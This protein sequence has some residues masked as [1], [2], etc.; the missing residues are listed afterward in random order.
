MSEQSTTTVERYR[1]TDD[2]LDSGSDVWGFALDQR[3]LGARAARGH[4]A[5]T[6]P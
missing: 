1:N 6:A 3:A 4:P 2:Q 5:A